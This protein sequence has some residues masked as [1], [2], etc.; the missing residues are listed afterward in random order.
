MI[1]GVVKSAHVSG[2]KIGMCGEMAGE[3]L[4]LPILVGMG[5]D[6][7]SMNALSILRVKKI[8]RSVSFKDCREITKKVLTFTT[9]REI[10]QYVIDEMARRFP[11]DFSGMKSTR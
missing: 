7:L 10:D 3:S 4:Y 8:L 9:A 6:E 5:L 2:I 1:K 11:D